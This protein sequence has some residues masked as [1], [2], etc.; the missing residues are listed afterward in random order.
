MGGLA[1]S[2]VR[3]VGA[4]KTVGSLHC[5]G[6]RKEERMTPI[7][8]FLCPVSWKPFGLSKAAPSAYAWQCAL[9]GYRA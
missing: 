1:E 9:L 5:I 8:F 4:G 6:V 3:S 7:V 2:T